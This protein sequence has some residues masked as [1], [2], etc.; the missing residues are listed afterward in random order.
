MQSWDNEEDQLVDRG[1]KRHG[2]DNQHPSEDRWPLD[3]ELPELRPPHR[4]LRDP[5]A[6]PLPGHVEAAHD[7]HL[8]QPVGQLGEMLVQQE[9]QQALNHAHRHAGH[10]TQVRAGAA[11]LRAEDRPPRREGEPHVLVQRHQPGH[12]GDGAPL[13]TLRLLVAV[14]DGCHHVVAD[15]GGYGHGCPGAEAVDHR[16][17]H[18]VDVL[19]HVVRRPKTYFRCKAHR[20]R[21]V[22]V[23]IGHVEHAVEGVLVATD[24]LQALDEQVG[25]S[26]V[27]VH[28]QRPV[29]DE[30][31]SVGLR[32]QAGL[33]VR[34]VGRAQNGVGVH[35]GHD[36]REGVK[37]LLDHQLAVDLPGCPV[38]VGRLSGRLIVDEDVLGVHHPAQPA[39]ALRLELPVGVAPCF[40]ARLRG[41]HGDGPL[42]EARLRR[43][44][45]EGSRE[46]LDGLLVGADDHHVRQRAL[47]GQLGGRLRAVEALPVVEVVHDRGDHGDGQNQHQGGQGDAVQDRGDDLELLPVRHVAPEHVRGRCEEH[48]GLGE[49]KGR[50]PRVVLAGVP[51]PRHVSNVGEH[52][53]VLGPL[54]AREAREAGGHGIQVAL[55][56]VAALVLAAG[57]PAGGGVGDG[58]LR[59][60]PCEGE[61]ITL[62]CLR[63]CRTRP[64][65]AAR[66]TTP[67][68]TWTDR[69]FA[70]RAVAEGG[71]QPVWRI[72]QRLVL[73]T[74]D[75]HGH[76]QLPGP[77]CPGP[78]RSPVRAGARSAGPPDLPPGRAW[79]PRS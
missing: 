18:R 50:Q 6:E 76:P 48:H 13:V 60:V 74:F 20:Q 19:R 72:Q 59:S 44:G 34:Q 63:H 30:P 73:K 52:L 32:A 79:P 53:G 65:G 69:T 38:L 33:H 25:V 5:K 4:A 39:A 35:Y 45:A 11:A 1:H 66:A 67:T 12:L 23:G 64:A 27:P 55:A 7:E 29:V 57:V 16:L 49:A 77:S 17:V 10:S 54:A 15:D 46:H 22:G 58:G 71:P 2:E 62:D 47:G 78:K 41:Q 51:L 14:G 9:E 37:S 43:D 70:V 61:A 68:A 28:V 36:D 31:P 24:E 21:V 42:M 26:K 3:G 40:I 56:R 75:R 8:P